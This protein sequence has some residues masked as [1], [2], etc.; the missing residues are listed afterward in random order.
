MEKTFNFVLRL[1]IWLTYFIQ[2][3]AADAIFIFGIAAYNV[4][5][6]GRVIPSVFFGNSIVRGVSDRGSFAISFL[7]IALSFGLYFFFTGQLRKFLKN[8]GVGIYFSKKNLVCLQQLVRISVLG[9]ILR[10][11]SNSLIWLI[12]NHHF[13]VEYAA[14]YLGGVPI[15]SDTNFA[16]ISS[17]FTLCV[18][19][20]IFKRGIELQNDIETF[21]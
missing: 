4:L 21:I 8:I 10:L 13:S 15:I 6:T 11:A 1:F 16:T 3:F 18:I 12:G 14:T 2:L 7:E 20:T 9:L 19:Y 5:H 17:V